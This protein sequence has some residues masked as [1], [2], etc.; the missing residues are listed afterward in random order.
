M[1][2]CGSLWMMYVCF[3]AP[4]R[5]PQVCYKIT[6]TPR[7][8]NRDYNYDVVCVTEREKFIVPLRASGAKAA[9]SLPSD[10]T[11]GSV[12]VKNSTM[13]TIVVRAC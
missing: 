4:A 7:E 10:F 2:V 12:A 9:L 8:Q 3:V 1:E 13:K 5:P 6:F 11:F